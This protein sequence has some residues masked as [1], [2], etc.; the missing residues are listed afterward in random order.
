MSRDPYNPFDD[1]ALGL[2][3]MGSIFFGA[4]TGIGIGVFVK[5]P[6]IGGLIGG[7]LGIIVG[8]WA[9]P[10]LMRDLRD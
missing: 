3:M 4:A 7:A 10:A 1:K 9:I 5:E 2:A 8:V 6:A